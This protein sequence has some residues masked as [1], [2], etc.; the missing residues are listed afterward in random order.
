VEFVYQA[1]QVQFEVS[2]SEIERVGVD[3]FSVSDGELDK[4]RSNI[5]SNGFH[6]LSVQIALN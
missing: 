2:Q 3:G 4:E 5:I 1:V 6:A